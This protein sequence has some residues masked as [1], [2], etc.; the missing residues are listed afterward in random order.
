MSATTMP[1]A[2]RRAKARCW[3]SSV[4][5][6][7]TRTRGAVP[8]GE[9]RRTRRQADAARASVVLPDAGARGPGGAARAAARCLRAPAARRRRAVDD[10]VRAVGI[11]DDGARHHD[12]ARADGLRV[13]RRRAARLHRADP[14]HQAFALPG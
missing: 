11:R 2:W 6:T 7:P 14:R 1:R 10:R 8:D 3:G 5:A 4:T 9:P 12:P 13:D